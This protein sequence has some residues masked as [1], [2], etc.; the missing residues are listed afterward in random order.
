M[1]ASLQNESSASTGKIWQ[2]L[3]EDQKPQVFASGK[4]A[5]TANAEINPGVERLP[6]GDL[7]KFEKDSRFVNYNLGPGDLDSTCNMAGVDLTN[8]A[9][10]QLKNLILRDVELNRR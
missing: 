6:Q 4:P 2:R 9:E 5:R 7:L 1:R 10:K 3:A 8:V